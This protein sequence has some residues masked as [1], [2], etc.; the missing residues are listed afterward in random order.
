MEATPHVVLC[1]LCGN[2]VMHEE[3]SNSASHNSIAEGLVAGGNDLLSF[4]AL[5]HFPLNPVT[6]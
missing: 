3:G 6:T 2:M 1:M 4:L 5:L